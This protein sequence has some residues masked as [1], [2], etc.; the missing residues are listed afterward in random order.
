MFLEI[1]SPDSTIF[2]GEVKSIFLPGEEGQFQVLNN[3]APLISNLNAGE[4]RIVTESGEK[5]SFKTN[6]GFVEVNKNKIIVLV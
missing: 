6:P 3:H 4:I 1:I 2:T 5:V